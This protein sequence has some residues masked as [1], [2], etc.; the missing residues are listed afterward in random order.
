MSELRVILNPE[1]GRGL[2]EKMAPRIE[3]VLR[4]SGVPYRLVRTTAPGHAIEL[5][6]E[7]VADGCQMV[8]SAGGDGT[9]HEVLNGLMDGA[10][11]H[12]RATLACIPAGSGNDFAVMNGVP[13]DV[14]AA[15]RLIAEGG[16]RTVDVGRVTIDDTIVRYF[17][18]V[19]GMGFDGLVN[20]HASRVKWLRGMMLYLPVVLKTIFRTLQP[21]DLEMV[22]DGQRESRREMMTIVANGPREGHTF[23]VAPEARC[24][25]GLFD[26]IELQEMSRLAMLA[27]VPTFLNGT[28]LK[29]P[30]S[31]QRH[32]R[33]VR[34]SSREPIY[35]HVDGEV[36]CETAHKVEIEMFPASLRMIGRP[37]NA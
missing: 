28:H 8:A 31:S 26:M 22:V 34:V 7:A 13:E 1:A 20:L 4:E 6:R 32:V 2:A 37:T 15:C 33:Q 24:D 25:D 16:T 3:A 11:G 21:M 12:A 27:A 23:L 30:K 17:D 5:A 29:N 18:N 36:L 9:S 10:N 35:M 14:E 19:V